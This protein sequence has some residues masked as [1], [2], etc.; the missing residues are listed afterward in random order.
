M[1][2]QAEES[3]KELLRFLCY[4]RNFGT[5]II[6]G[7]WAVYFYNPYFGSVDIDVV[8][9]S[10]GGAFHDALDSYVHANGYSLASYPWM[11]WVF[12]LLL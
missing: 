3:H 11:Q 12:N 1:D 4:Y 7:G 6:I 8:G 2:V 9:P 10:M 5:P